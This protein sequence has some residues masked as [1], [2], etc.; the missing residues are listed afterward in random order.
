[1]IQ[2]LE[3]EEAQISDIVPV[4]SNIEEMNLDDE[5]NNSEIDNDQNNDT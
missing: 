1:M 4:P 5:S 2:E 3:S